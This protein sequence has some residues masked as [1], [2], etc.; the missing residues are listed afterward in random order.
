MFWSRS[1]TFEQLCINFT[2]ERLQQFFNTFVF[3][4]E[5]ALYN[6]EGISWDPLDFPDNQDAVDLLS[7]KN[8]GLFALL[9]E[10]CVIPQGSDRSYV[11]KL[12]TRFAA[13]PHKRF[14]AVKTNQDAF[15]L[16]HFAGPVTYV[17]QGFL[18]KNKD[19]LN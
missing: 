12:K 3:K 15:V 17:T 11:S 19:Q 1:N 14:E 5:E 6:A 18:E 9:D 16:K 10:E 4:L 2:N 8:T 7:D 13:E